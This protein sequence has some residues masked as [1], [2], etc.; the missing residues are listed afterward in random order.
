[1]EAIYRHRFRLS[2]GEAG[3]AGADN[4]LLFAQS[5]ELS[6]DEI[7]ITYYL[8]REFLKFLA[9]HPKLSHMLVTM[10]GKDGNPLTDLVLSDLE[11]VTD[12]LGDLSLDYTETD[13]PTL[14]AR[15][16]YNRRQLVIPD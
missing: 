13:L 1:M 7:E 5:I 12:G 11:L 9:D 14:S 8:C 3:K 15:Y 10:V 6:D 2:V 16:S 4:A